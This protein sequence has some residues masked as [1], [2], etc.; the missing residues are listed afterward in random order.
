MCETCERLKRK[1]MPVDVWLAEHRD[2][3]DLSSEPFPH[4]SGEWHTMVCSCGA[5]LVVSKAR[6]AFHDHLDSCQQC[7]DHPFNLCAVGAR[8]LESA[9]R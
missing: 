4:P 3:G 1:V 7:A 8:L 2:H 6:T 9:G 5:R